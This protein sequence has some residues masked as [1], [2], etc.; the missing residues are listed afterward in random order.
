MEVIAKTNGAFLI[1]ATETEIKEIVN[2]V[3]GSRPKDIEI[4]QKLPAIDYASTITKIKTLKE[5]SNYKYLIQKKEDFNAAV[6]ILVAAV[7]KASSIE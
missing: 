4:G 5:N 6:D 7:E 1:Q 2:A 3:T